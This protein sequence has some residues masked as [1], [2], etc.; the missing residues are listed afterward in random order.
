MHKLRIFLALQIILA[1]MSMPVYA[2][3]TGTPVATVPNSNTGTA[4]T[5]SSGGGASE[6]VLGSGNVV[7]AYGNL[8]NEVGDATNNDTATSVSVTLAPVVASVLGFFAVVIPLG[9]LAYTGLELA[10]IFFKPLRPMFG[11]EGGSGGDMSGGSGGKKVYLQVSEDCIAAIN[12]ANGSG[13][14]MS[15]SGGQ[16]SLGDIALNYLKLRFKT[17]VICIVTIGLLATPVGYKIILK[18]TELIFFVIGKVF[19]FIAG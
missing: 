9:L 3:N 10:C 5:D 18:L 14:D 17:L 2:D 7:S 6:D 19:S 8:F 16:K 15:G 13:G 11:A 1:S 4:V 12:S